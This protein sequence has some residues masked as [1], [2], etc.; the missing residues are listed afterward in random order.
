MS[1]IVF[2]DEIMSECVVLLNCLLEMGCLVEI[3]EALTGKKARRE[4]VLQ[5]VIVIFILGISVY[6]NLCDGNRL[7]QLLHYVGL[8]VI[9]KLRY[10]MDVIDTVTY[11][12]LAFLIGGALE[13]LIYVPYNLICHF[14]QVEGDYSVFVVLIAFVTCCMINKK[15][16]IILNGKWFDLYKKR[17]NVQFLILLF[18]FLLSFII[19]LVKFGKGLSWGEGVYLSV[20][21]FMFFVLIY[22]IS[23]YQIEINCHKRYADKYGEV[24]LELRERQ[25]KFM[26]QLDSVYALCK[27]YDSYDELVHHQMIELNNLKK[28]LMSGKLLI[29]ERPL[30]VAHIYTKMCEAEEKQIEMQTEFSCSLENIDV[31][32]IFLIEIIGNLLDNAMDEVSEREKHERIRMEIIDDGNEIC[33]SVGNEHE[34]IPYKEY[35]LFF[36][37]GY[38]TKGESR[39]VGLPYVKKIVDKFHGHIEIGNVKYGSCNYFVISVYFNR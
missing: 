12:I 1:F 37:D 4:K 16:L 35:S 13:L 30:V 18:V 32:D 5:Y 17:I 34:K 21:L 38:S 22:K 24:I 36:K 20:A 15:K 26:N 8:F 2:R 6:I 31:P 19:S 11:A 33:I 25:H 27:I 14:F 3:V 10:G 39:G 29:L 7:L 9:F 28:Y 23:A